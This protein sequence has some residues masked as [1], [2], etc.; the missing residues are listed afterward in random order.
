MLP[1]QG[2]VSRCDAKDAQRKCIMCDICPINGI[3]VSRRCWVDS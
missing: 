3:L 1:G 2:D